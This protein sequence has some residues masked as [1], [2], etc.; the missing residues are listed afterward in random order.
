MT[1]SIV[2]I[3]IERREIGFAIASCTWDAGMVGTAVA[4]LGA[5]CSQAQGYFP[6]HS[7]F[8]EKLSEGLKVS[9]ILEEFRKTD[10]DFETRQVGM[11]SFTGEAFAFTG[12]ETDDYAGHIIGN[13]YT[14]QGNILTG[15]DVLE[16]MAKAFEST[17]GMLAERLYA[18][19]QAGDDVGGDLRGKMSARVLVKKKGAGLEDTYIDFTVEDHDEPVHEIGRLLGVLKKVY[20]AYQ[21]QQAVEK[22]ESDEKI[23]AL[24][25]MELYLSDKVDRT[26][27]DY[28]T[29]VGETSLEL[30]L[31]EKAVQAFQRVLMISPGLSRYLKKEKEEGR[32]AADFIDQVFSELDKRS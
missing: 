12:T 31:R 20:R 14:C 8:Y 26:V 4:E 15:R 1:F 30:G 9:E 2:G 10:E 32:M 6:F 5:L 24:E 21:L 28:H 7:L 19:L 25:E 27:V 11:V 3:D 23:S 22:A 16:S 18:A 13:G 17:K 29:F